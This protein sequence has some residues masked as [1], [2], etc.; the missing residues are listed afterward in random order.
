M[1]STPREV[2]NLW[3]AKILGDPARMESLGSSFKFVVEG[4]G[5]GTW[6]LQCKS[7]VKVIEGDAPADCTIRVHAKD[8][9][10]LGTGSMN[11]QVAYMMGKLKVSGDKALALKLNQII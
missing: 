10:A 4:D 5:G 3:T 11:P 9:V 1:T 8:L 2:I 6:V 7:P